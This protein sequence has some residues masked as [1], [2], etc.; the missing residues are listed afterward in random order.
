MSSNHLMNNNQSNP[1]YDNDESDDFPICQVPI[2]NNNQTSNEQ[3]IKVGP[4]FGQPSNGIKFGMSGSIYTPPFGQPSNGIKFGMSESINT[5]PEFGGP[6]P[7]TVSSSVSAGNLGMAFGCFRPPTTGIAF[8]NCGGPP[9]S[10]PIERHPETGQP[11]NI[12]ACGGIQTQGIP[13]G[14][15]PT[16]DKKKNLDNVYAKLAQARAKIAELN[17]SLDEIYEILPKTQ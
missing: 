14:V 4:A 5:P 10:R 16:D 12:S 2:N 9:V 7:T 17:K 13:F 8:G 6:R 3:Q 11:I 1:T 15:R